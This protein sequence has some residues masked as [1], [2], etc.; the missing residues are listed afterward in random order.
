MS[1]VRALLTALAAAAVTAS[2]GCEVGGDPDPT[3]AADGPAGSSTTALSGP[4]RQLT[5]LAQGPVLAWD[6]QRMTSRQ[7]ALFAG[8]TYLRT[9]T[10]Y[11]PATDLAGQKEL[12]G[13]LATDT[14]KPNKD[15][16]SWTFTLRE[17]VTW[18]DGSAVTC[19]DVRYGV[20]RSLA[21]ETAS[22]GYALTYLDIP[23]KP[24]GSSEYPGP[25]G[26]AGQSEKATKLIED[27]VRCDGRK[28][29]FRLSEPVPTFAA[30]VST[31]ELAPYKEAQDERDD[32][33]YSVF[34]NG[35]YQLEGEWV[36]SQGGTWVPNPRWDAE[37]D[38]VR[39][40]G[41]ERI[42]HREGVSA[43]D[44]VRL[45]AE[46][47][48][49]SRAALLD[50]LP[51]GL[52][53]PVRESPARLQT[54]AADGQLVD[55][56]AP[57]MRSEVM[58]EQEVRV[59]LALATDRQAYVEA[60]GGEAVSTPAWSL[61]GASLPSAHQAVLDRG[62][63]GDPDAA[64]ERLKKAKKTSPTV[65]V[66]YRPGQ[67]ADAAMKALEAG[68]ERAGFE[69]E[70]KPV[71]D[72]YFATI[73][74]ADAAEDYDVFWSSWGPDYP[75]AATVLPLLFDDRINISD[76]GSGRDYGYVASKNLN[77]DMDAAAAERDEDKRM[78]RWQEVDQGLL[79][80]GRYIP[81]AQQRNTFVAGSE[82]TGLAANA[83]FGGALETGLV[84]VSR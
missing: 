24:D 15:A 29:T 35:P 54:V 48:G 20:A 2:A 81:L 6:P 34:S 33:V 19:E 67:R 50:P 38:E 31:T 78:T 70:L 28:V 45:M 59:A 55:Y 21:P 17:G 23:K 39:D 14:G 62:P 84:G 13:D 7:Q 51:A 79:E 4:Q 68:W 69:I 22:T 36:P 72:D 3:S 61:I 57:N 12:V 44:A 42:D 60:L 80:T 49:G 32:G 53:D 27:A 73:S 65:R 56:L 43:V 63:S 83:V 16:T 77:R 76:A 46:G 5:V 58:K 64:A 74:G 71:G 41:P 40:P 47:E 30:V 66:A 18:Q 52:L 25:Y 9:L 26:K 1:H 75:S 8:R 11:R 10:T 82:V 37:S